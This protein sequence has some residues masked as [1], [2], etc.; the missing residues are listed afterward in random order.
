MFGVKPVSRL[1][2]NPNA[3]GWAH[4]FFSVA[5]FMAG[6]YEDAVRSI[7]R[8]PLESLSRIGLGLR[9]AVP[10]W[11]HQQLHSLCL[12]LLNVRAAA[13]TA[14]VLGNTT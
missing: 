13:V 9:A 12:R 7:E 10:G 8:R 11:L 6:R 2:L 1:R 14:V 4:G 5:Y 3:P